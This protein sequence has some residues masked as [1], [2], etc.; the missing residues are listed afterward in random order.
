MYVRGDVAACGLAV[1]PAA[2]G[3]SAVPRFPP[4]LRQRRTTDRK[5]FELRW[6]RR[7]LARQLTTHSVSLGT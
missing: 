7:A 5:M 3:G 4:A 6:R 1:A 2:G